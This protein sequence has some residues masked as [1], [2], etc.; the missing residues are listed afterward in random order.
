MWPAVIHLNT[1]DAQIHTEYAYS[2]RVVATTITA[3]FSLRFWSQPSQRAHIHSSVH[4]YPL[5]LPIQAIRPQLLAATSCHTHTHTY[6]HRSEP[7][8]CTIKASSNI[9]QSNSHRKSS[10]HTN[11]TQPI[12]PL[13]PQQYSTHQTTHSTRSLRFYLMFRS[14]LRS[15]SANE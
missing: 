2:N 4:K 1:L 13:S 10:P 11:P 15:V 12:P 5:H 3:L 14:A 7:Q 8:T 9:R 6:I